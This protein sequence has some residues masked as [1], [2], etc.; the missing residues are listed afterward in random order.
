MSGRGDAQCPVEA[1]PSVRPVDASSRLP[2]CPPPHVWVGWLVGGWVGGW[3]VGGWGGWV[4]MVRAY[5]RACV[6]ASVHVRACV[7]ACERVCV[8]VHA[9]HFPPIIETHGQRTIGLT[10]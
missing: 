2:S 9:N 8:C 7:R 6:R 1:K 5:V 10:T 3:V 4:H